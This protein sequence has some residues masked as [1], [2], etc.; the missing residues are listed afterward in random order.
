MIVVGYL[1]AALFFLAAFLFIAW[2]W[3]EGSR[4]RSI[5]MPLLLVGAFGIMALVVSR[6]A[7]GAELEWNPAIRGD[8]EV[9]GPWENRTEMVALRPDHTFDYRI[10]S[11]TTTGTWTRDDW[12]LYLH[13]GHAT[14]TMKFV[15]YRRHL[16]LMTHALGDPDA[17]DGD[18]GLER[19]AR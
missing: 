12:N 10:G 19:A 16:R 4:W 2:F 3:R 18:L 17:W 13:K 15:K 1:L 6:C 8:A 7:V 11:Q 14:G 9:F 5:G